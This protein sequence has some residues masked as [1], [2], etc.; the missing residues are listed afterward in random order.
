MRVHE[1]DGCVRD[2]AGLKIHLLANP[3]QDVAL[4]GAARQDR[5]RSAAAM[6]CLC[7][8]T[9]QTAGA[10][11]RTRKKERHSQLVRLLGALL[12]REPEA[13]FTRLFLFYDRAAENVNS[14]K[15]KTR[16]E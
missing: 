3:G 12:V 2:N 15:Q 11:R 6:S 10:T 13:P 14:K 16:E 4:I 9:T 1:I 8:A 7:C 5:W